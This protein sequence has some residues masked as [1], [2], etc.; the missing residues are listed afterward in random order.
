[1]YNGA[2][3]YDIGVAHQNYTMQADGKVF[4]FLESV[5]PG[6]VGSG[7]EPVGRLAKVPTFVGKGTKKVV[8]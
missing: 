4:C 5:R 7:N 1:L 3:G 2:S 8:I 6:R